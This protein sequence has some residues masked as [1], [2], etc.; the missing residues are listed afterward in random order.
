MGLSELLIGLQILDR[1]QGLRR[2]RGSFSDQFLHLRRIFTHRLGN[3]FPFNLLFR[4]NLQR[5]VQMADPLLHRL[6][7]RVRGLDVGVGLGPSARATVNGL[8]S[9]VVPNSN[10]MAIE[11][12]MGAEVT[13]RW[14][15]DDIDRTLSVSGSSQ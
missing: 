14:V 11:R 7:R 6:G 8:A 15:K 9:I 10:A 12:A 2:R 1:S 4:R 3:T 5:R 13:R